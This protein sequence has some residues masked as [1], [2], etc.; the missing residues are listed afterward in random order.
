MV[1]RKK[2]SNMH[3]NHGSISLSERVSLHKSDFG[4]L[5][6]CI[7][8]LKNDGWMTFLFEM[9]TFQGTCVFFLGGGTFEGMNSFNGFGAS[10]TWKQ[11]LMISEIISGEPMGSMYGIFTYI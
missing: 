4:F 6:Q 8:N 10:L 2:K 7:S 5:K 11:H 3:I 1:L 9:V